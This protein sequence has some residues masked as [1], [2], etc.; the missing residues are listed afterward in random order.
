MNSVPRLHP[1]LTDKA[2]NGLTDTITIGGLLWVTV[3]IVIGNL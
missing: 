1:V 3:P 2:G